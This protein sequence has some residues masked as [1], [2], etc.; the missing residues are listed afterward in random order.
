MKI[1][2]ALGKIQSF[3]SQASDSYFCDHIS[4]FFKADDSRASANYTRGLE[5]FEPQQLA[6]LF[7]LL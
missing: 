6:T 3:D 4:L 2:N 5:F 1:L 7:L